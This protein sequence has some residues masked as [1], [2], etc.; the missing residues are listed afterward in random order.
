LAVNKIGGQSLVFES[1]PCV[2]SWAAVVGPMEGEGPLK[3]EYDMIMKDSLLD[4]DSWE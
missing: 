1:K 2:T 4:Q 3:S